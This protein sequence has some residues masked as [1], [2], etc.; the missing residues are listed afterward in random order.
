VPELPGCPAY[1]RV[2]DQFDQ[3]VGYVPDEGERVAEFVVEGE[4]DTQLLEDLRA[5]SGGTADGST[6]RIRLT[7]APGGPGNVDGVIEVDDAIVQL[8]AR[9]VDGDNIEVI[10]LG[11]SEQA[12]AAIAVAVACYSGTPL[13]EGHTG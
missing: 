8:R 13:P 3:R 5:C 1:A 6:I 11:T 7:S 2:T 4:G 12:D 9:V 10:T